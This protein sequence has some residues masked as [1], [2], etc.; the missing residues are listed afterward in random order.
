MKFGRHGN[1][2][3][4]ISCFEVI[5]T[6]I[7]AN[8]SSSSL[9]R[10]TK[11]KFRISNDIFLFTFSKKNIFAAARMRFIFVTRCAGNKA[12]F[13]FGLNHRRLKFLEMFEAFFIMYL[14]EHDYISEIIISFLGRKPFQFD[15][16]GFVSGFVW[17][18]WRRSRP[19]STLY[20]LKDCVKNSRD[21]FHPF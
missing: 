3:S 16:R 21:P 2:G 1:V 12:L 4:H 14:K 19:W 17:C 6:T 11:I 18:I 15:M 7:E 8:S 5:Y 20:S 9:L 10:P 13:S